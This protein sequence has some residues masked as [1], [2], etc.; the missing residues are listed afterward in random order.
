MQIYRTEREDKNKP[1]EGYT[2]NLSS[3]AVIEELKTASSRVP[4]IEN[5]CY[6]VDNCS[7]P[8]CLCDEAD[9]LLAL[10]PGGI[11]ATTPIMIIGAPA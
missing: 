8:S 1:L 3:D 5:I 4:N 11:A 6:Q 7:C 2:T 10:A 9:F